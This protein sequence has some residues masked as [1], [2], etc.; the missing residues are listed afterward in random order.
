MARHHEVG[1]MPPSWCTFA[2]EAHRL[3]AVFQRTRCFLFQYGDIAQFAISSDAVGRFLPRG[4]FAWCQR[5]E[6]TEYK[7]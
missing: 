5:A 7:I 6:L 2:S 3:R 1:I 4:E